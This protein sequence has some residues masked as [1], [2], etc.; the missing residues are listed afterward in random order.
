MY[1]APN[2]EALE[3]SQAIIEYLDTAEEEGAL[4][5]FM[6]DDL[7][8]R[9]FTNVEIH[10]SL[11][12]GVMGNQV[13][14]PENNQLPRDLFACGQMRQAVSL[15]HSN[16]QTRIDKMGVVLNYGQMPLVKSRYL[17]KIC[18]EQHPYG[19][20]VIAAIMCYGGYNVEDSILFN[21]GSIK[22]GLF[23]TT[24]YNMYESKEES[25]KV[26]T[27]QVD[28][29]FA[30]IE[31]ANVI[32]LRNGFDYSQLDEH[33]LIKENTPLD[34]K[35]VIIGKITT[36]LQDPGASMD[37]S[38]VPKKGQLGFVDKSFITEGEE[39]FRV[40]KVRVRHERVPA[41]GDKFCSRCGQKGTIGLVIPE[42]NMPFTKEGIRPDI[43]IN[44]H[45]LPS[46]MTIGQLV[47]TLMGKACAMYGGFGDCTAFMN[48]GQKATSFGKML[49]NVGFNSSGNQILLNG[50]SGE[51]MYAEIFIGPTYYMRLKHMV[52]DKINY[53]SKGPRTLLTRQTVQGRANDG[54]LRVGEME[55]DG[56]A[57]H[58]ATAFLQ[59]SMLVRGDQYFMAVCNKTGMT[60]IY[61]Q[62][63]NLFLSPIADGPIKFVGT[64][65]EG[66]NIENISKHGRSFSVIR[67]P[68][69]FKLL[70]QELQGMN[71]QMRIITE[72][73]IDQLSSMAFSDNIV[74]LTGKE[75]I[76]AAQVARNAQTK[77]RPR[78][79]VMQGTPKPDPFAQDSPEYRPPES[80]QAAY[81]PYSPQAALYDEYGQLHGGPMYEGD[82][83]REP[84]TGKMH[85][86]MNVSKKDPLAW[87]WMFDSSDYE[88]GDI[89]R[90]L[91]IED[92]GRPSSKWWVD[93]HDYQDPAEHPHGWDNGDLV[94]SDGTVIEDNAVISA[95]LSDQHPGNWK[96]VIAKLNPG[97][98]PEAVV[99]PESPPYAPVSPPYAPGSSPY[100]PQSPQYNP[101]S[102]AFVPQS[103]QYNPN[104][105][106]FKPQ[107]PDDK[108]NEKDS[109]P[110]VSPQY[111]AVSPNYAP[112]TPVDKVGGGNSQP[113]NVNIY[114]PGA[115]DKKDKPAV[116][117]EEEAADGMQNTIT[118][119]KKE[120]IIDTEPAKPTSDSLLFNE[121]SGSSNGS[122]DKE[123]Q[124]GGEKKKV[125]IVDP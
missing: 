117:T 34:E 101:N 73:N 116:S 14:F 56:I 32:G 13:V 67:I 51:Q 77:N 44:P 53:R 76:T 110:I 52:K 108:P 125:T 89:F 28:S 26:G 107:T 69:A 111:G 38:V 60:A 25:S 62:S 16:F 78:P 115:D 23:R 120:I 48:K 92:D 30:N 8:K 82:G 103:P 17:D 27:S 7:S 12:L 57:A 81:D 64:L 42:E 124:S 39:G 80:P 3:P 31:S 86:D 119:A 21:E 11:I 40:A 105:P 90:S 113:V 46:R 96:R 74:R 104:S 84:K 95:L 68:Y 50:E 85:L 33:G 24:Y 97:K 29:Q 6:E 5:A 43:I 98:Y 94:K 100:V 15:Y 93:D 61:N 112:E 54:G 63:Y 75:D 59:E 121:D 71:I 122:D 35:K 109:L 10:P 45:A 123:E 91:I 114:M 88:S 19:E 9:P 66:L 58:G 102:P 22:R 37:D 55:R 18:K 49:T 1:N 2:M 72:E 36:N 47:E 4:I 106:A 99:Q 83:Q 87:G 118:S 41:I 79:P 65:N 20:N 70:M